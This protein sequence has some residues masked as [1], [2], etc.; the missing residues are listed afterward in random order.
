MFNLTCR[1]RDSRLL[2]YDLEINVPLKPSRV[3]Y[4]G[5]K[6]TRRGGW[7]VLTFSSFS[8]TKIK[9]LEY[10]FWS[11]VQILDAAD[12]AEREEKHKAIIQVPSTN[13][14]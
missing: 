4:E 13:R 9:Q 10:N 2:G 7:I 14:K 3:T 1:F 6:N 8:P 12:K 5:K 11:V